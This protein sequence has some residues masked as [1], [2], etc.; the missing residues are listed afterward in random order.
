MNHYLEHMGLVTDSRNGRVKVS[1]TGSGCSS[2]HKSLCMLGESKAK[3][4]ELTNPDN[5]YRAGEEV[6]VRINPGSG[7]L[8]VFVLYLIPFALMVVTLLV[9]TTLQY[10]EGIAGLAALVMLVPY[11]LTVYG[12]RNSLGRNCHIEIMNR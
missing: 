9:A 8:A 6:V 7:Y 3:E 12:F 10:S 5:R 1:L 11:F 4:V 2:C